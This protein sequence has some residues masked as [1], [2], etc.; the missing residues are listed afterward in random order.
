[1]SDF[2]FETIT[3]DNGELLVKFDEENVKR[4]LDWAVEKWRKRLND[5][6]QNK[7]KVGELIANCYIDAFLSV[8]CSLF[9]REWL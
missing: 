7:S 2:P 4:Y 8:K 6:Q 9:G 3:K 5:A 1:M